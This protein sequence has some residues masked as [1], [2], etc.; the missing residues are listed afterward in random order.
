MIWNTLGNIGSD[1]NS[2]STRGYPTCSNY[3]DLP[4][5]SR[6]PR[7]EQNRLGKEKY[8]NKTAPYYMPTGDRPGPLKLAV[9]LSRRKHH[10]EVTHPA[11]RSSLGRENI[12]L[13]AL[14]TVS[15]RALHTHLRR[16]CRPRFQI[17][18]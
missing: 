16:V 7:E 11:Q 14:E 3:P 1:S 5:S 8:T 4:T 17:R 9:L 2:S 15:E 6:R 13:D 12:N 10:T 18:K